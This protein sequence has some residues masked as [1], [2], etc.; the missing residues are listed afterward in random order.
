MQIGARARIEVAASPERV[1]A[2][3]T[4]LRNFPRLM[5]PH[6]IIP[7]IASAEMAAGAT[8]AAGARRFLELSDGNTIEEEVLAFDRPSRHRYR[9]VRPPAG[10]FGLLVRGG[11]GN[12]SFAPSERGQGTTLVWSYRF[13]LT[14]IWVYPVAMLVVSQFQRWMEETLERVRS[15]A[16]SSG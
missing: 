1:F 3:A 11:E 14:S 8:P 7:G 13:E 16:V 5:L 12:W 9:W 6:G 2:V 4:D 10:S 15:A